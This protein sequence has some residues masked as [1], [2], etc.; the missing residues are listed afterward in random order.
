MIISLCIRK[1]KNIR[2]VREAAEKDLF[3]VAR[4]LRGGG[5]VGK[6]GPPRKNNF[7]KLE[8]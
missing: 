6:A 7:F 1:R 4:P 5:G 3:L 2:H 8:K